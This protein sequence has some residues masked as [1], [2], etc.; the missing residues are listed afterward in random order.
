MLYRV[1]SGSCCHFYVFLFL[2]SSR[3]VCTATVSAQ[4]GVVTPLR[5]GKPI[6]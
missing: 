5:F 3:H 1:C 6:K 4:C 2:L